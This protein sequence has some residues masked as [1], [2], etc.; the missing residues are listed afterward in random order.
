MD[1]GTIMTAI[2]L[3]SSGLL[4]II[5]VVFFMTIRKVDQKDFDKH[6]ENDREDKKGMYADI[7]DMS[8][9]VTEIHTILKERK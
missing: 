7:K 9:K 4:S 2:V 1:E 6:C 5:G 3:T 8:N